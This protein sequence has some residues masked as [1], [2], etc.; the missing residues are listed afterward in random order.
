[1]NVRYSHVDSTL[2]LR[3]LIVTSGGTDSSA[4]Y[5]SGNGVGAGLRVVGGAGNGTGM[6]IDGGGG[7]SNG[8]SM[9][10]SGTGD[11]FR[12]VGGMT[13]DGA[14][15]RGGTTSGHGIVSWAQGSGNGF[16]AVGDDDSAG[17]TFLGNGSGAGLYAEGGIT[18]D[19]LYATGGTTSGSGLVGVGVGAS[20]TYKDLK[21]TNIDSGAFQATVSGLAAGVWGYGGGREIDGGYVD[22]NKTEQGGISGGDKNLTIFTI[23]TSGVDD[24]LDGVF[25]TL[26]NATGVVKAVLSTNSSGAAEAVVSDGTWNVLASRYGFE[27]P[28]TSYVITANDTVGL[29]GYDIAIP[30]PSASET[31]RV[32]GFLYDLNSQ[33]ESGVTISA[34]LPSGVSRSGSLIVSPFSVATT[35]DSEGYFFLDLIKSTSLIPSGTEYEITISRRDG[36]LLRRRVVVPDQST[37]QL[38]W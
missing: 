24:T 4:V 27:F 6:Y 34:Y 37:W 32:Y 12:A 7:N 8:L 15:F 35:S 3:G 29:L 18:G 13:G 2:N 9:A 10:G 23:D 21:V 20:G 11:G 38:T 26:Q 30:S 5:L 17:A 1:G 14:D 31:C 33:P 16:R 25:I 28:D 22:S 19:G 36:T